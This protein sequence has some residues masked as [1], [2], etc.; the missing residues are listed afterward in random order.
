MRS[1]VVRALVGLF[2]GLGVYIRLGGELTF[3]AILALATSVTG[4]ASFLR[5]KPRWIGLATFVIA[6]GALVGWTLVL[7]ERLRGEHRDEG[8][9][10]TLPRTD[11]RVKRLDGGWILPTDDG[12]LRIRATSL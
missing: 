2:I 6:G 9:D 3:I 1:P 8:T 12:S 11:R 5:T 7:H 10:P 4:A